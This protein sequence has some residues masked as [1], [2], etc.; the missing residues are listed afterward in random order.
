MTRRWDRG[1]GWVAA[2]TVLLLATVGATFVGSTLPTRLR[3][4]ARGLG[5]VG[6]LGG[7][8]VFL[9]GV[10][11]L[12]ESLTPLPRPKPG[13]ALVT[14]GVYGVV[15]HPI[16]SGVLLAALG[17]ALLRGRWLGLLAVAALW[18]FFDAKA[19]REEAWLAERFPDYPAYRQR[20]A[21]LVPGLY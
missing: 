5:V 12:G 16:Y 15:R 6:V 9:A 13:G 3:G 11:N 17:W 7:G 2:Q 14:S 10:L 18:S 4:A 21:K 19:S 8:S 20:V 1:E